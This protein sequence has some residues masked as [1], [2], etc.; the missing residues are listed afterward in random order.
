MLPELPSERERK[1]IE[2]M[3]FYA[4][5]L[6]TFCHDTESRPSETSP[7][8][9]AKNKRFKRMCLRRVTFCVRQKVTKERTKGEPLT[10]GFPLWNPLPY[11]RKSPP[12]NHPG[13]QSPE[14]TEAPHP[15]WRAAVVDDA[16]WLPVRTLRGVGT[17]ERDTKPKP[18][19]SG[20]GLE[21]RRNG[22]SLLSRIRASK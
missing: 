7:P 18:S 4:C 2:T 6:P 3:G 20:F 17:E 16:V 15:R 19:V 8:A 10:M 13:R 12:Q 11:D 14:L 22:T 1:Y 5:S 21:R 9:G